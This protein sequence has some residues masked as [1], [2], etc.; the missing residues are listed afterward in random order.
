MLSTSYVQL[1][2]SINPFSFINLTVRVPIW[3]W[4]KVP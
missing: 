3:E 2:N 1:K 4:Y